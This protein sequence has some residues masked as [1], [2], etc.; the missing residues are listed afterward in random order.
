MLLNVWSLDADRERR[1][2]KMGRGGGVLFSEDQNTVTWVCP[3]TENVHKASTSNTAGAEMNVG[4]HETHRAL[5]LRL[6]W[7][8]GFLWRF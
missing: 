4:M 6:W 7:P 2:F 1:R 3:S 8:L 5:N